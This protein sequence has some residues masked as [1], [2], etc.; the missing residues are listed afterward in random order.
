MEK[1]QLSET[2][3]ALLHQGHAVELRAFGMS[4]FPLLRPGSLVKLI[5]LPMSDVRLG[6]VV[7]FRKDDY[8]VIHRVRKIEEVDHG[9]CFTCKGDSNLNPDAPVYQSNYLGKVMAIKRRNQWVKWKN[10]SLL[11]WLI[12]HTGKMY[13]LPFWLYKHTKE[14]VRKE[15]RSNS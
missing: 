3:E 4:M 8:V 12:L 9:F 15:L 6:D 1:Q 13:S 11:T 10:P 2:V 5:H 7:A 14:K